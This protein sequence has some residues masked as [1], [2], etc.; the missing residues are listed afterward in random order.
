VLGA[1]ALQAL[2]RRAVRGFRKVVERRG[3]GAD[4]LSRI[5]TISR[6]LRYSTATVLVLSAAC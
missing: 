6:V 3:A 1:W 5:D 4:E 2:A